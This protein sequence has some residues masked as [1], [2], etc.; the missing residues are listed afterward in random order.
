[1]RGSGCFAEQRRGAIARFPIASAGT[2]RYPCV[3][4]RELRMDYRRTAPTVSDPARVRAAGAARRA[5][6]GG[7]RSFRKGARN[8]PSGVRAGRRSRCEAAS[9]Q[10]G[11]AR[12]SALSVSAGR[13]HPARARGRRRGARLRRSARA[14]VRHLLR[15]RA[16]RP[17]SAP[18]VAD[19]PRGTRPVAAVSGSVPRQP[20]GRCA[21]MPELRGAHR[22]RSHERP[23][24]AHRATLADSAQP[25]GLRARVRMAARAERADAR[26]HRAAR[27]HGAEGSQQRLRTRN[28]CI[29]ACGARGAVAAMGVA[30]RGAAATDRGADRRAVDAGRRRSA[31]R[32]L[33]EVRARQSRSG[34]AALRCIHTR[35]WPHGSDC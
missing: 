27:A 6:R 10:R 33:D 19:E 16:G 20:R 7:A 25:A 9:R 18:R 23:R 12:L 22:A 13:A 15:E 30:A 17:Q 35:A 24:A 21:R 4:D 8:V 5:R 2:C 3:A 26:A 31:A 11:A 14:D 29:P 34:D 32:G 28:R 1:M